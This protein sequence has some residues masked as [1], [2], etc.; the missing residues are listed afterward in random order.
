MILVIDQGTT[1]T[2]AIVFGLDAAPVASAQ[3][4]FPQIYPR[5][6]WVEHDPEALWETTLLTAREALRRADARRADLAAIGITNQRETT[7]LWERDRAAGGQRHRLAGPADG[8]GL[9]AAL[10]A[11]GRNGRCASD[12]AGPRSLFFGDQG[13][14]AARRGR[15]L[16]ARAEAGEIAFGTVD[17]FLIWRLTGGKTSTPP[18]SPTPRARCSVTCAT[19]LFSDAL[20]GC[21]ACRSPC[22]PKS[23]HGGRVSARRAGIWAPRYS[24]PGVAGDQQAALYGQDCTEP[25]MLNATFGTGAFLLMNVGAEP[26]PSSD[27]VAWTDVAARWRGETAYALEGAIFSPA[28]SSSGCATDS[29]SSPARRKG[30]AARRSLPDSGGVTSSPP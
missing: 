17:S 25:G 29:G 12:G 22:C 1:S 2:R 7:L 18:M 11:E 16:R 4:E 8:R 5:P 13:S 6:G 14:L 3:A 21:L 15:G 9:C 30:R 28:R 27:H 24:D 20:C 19:R 26:A 10:K 23:W